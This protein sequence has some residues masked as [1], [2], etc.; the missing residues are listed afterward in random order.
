MTQQFISK[1]NMKRRLAEITCS[2]EIYNVTFTHSFRQHL[3]LSYL[4]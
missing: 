2:N 3:L 4:C 1:N